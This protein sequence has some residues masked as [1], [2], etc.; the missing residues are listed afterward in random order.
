MLAK[1]FENVKCCIN[2]DVLNLTTTFII[3]LLCT[4]F[5]I[6]QIRINMTVFFKEVI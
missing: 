6:I 2:P 4:V 5:P 1:C 3:V